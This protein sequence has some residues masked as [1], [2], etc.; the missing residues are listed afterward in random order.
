MGE[1]FGVAFLEAQSAGLP[2]VAGNDGGVAEVVGDGESGLLV[3]PR[4]AAAFADGVAHLL[5]DD[6]LRARLSAGA[7]ARI[8]AHH[9]LERAAE[10]LRQ[11][12]EAAREK[13]RA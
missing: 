8:A 12:I 2:V 7:T 1:A 11:A 5:H 6:A 10:T 3:P 13:R 9:S 4:D